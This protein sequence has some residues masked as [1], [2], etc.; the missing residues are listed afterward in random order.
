MRIEKKI[1]MLNREQKEQF[2]E[3]LDTLGETL[4]ITETEYKAAVKSYQAVGEWLSG[5][6]SMLAPYAPEILP[7]GSFMLGTMIRAV[8]EEDDLDIDLV[9]QLKGK[10]PHWTQAILKEKVGDQLKANKMFE[11]L[12]DEEGRRCWTLLYRRNTEYK[13]ERYHMDIL[14]CVVDKDYH[15]ILE[16][17]F[18][19]VELSQDDTDSLAI[20]ITDNETENYYTETDHLEWMKSNPFGYARWFFEQASINAGYIRLLM[21]SIEPVP[22]Y[23]PEKLPLQR[24]IQILKRHRDMM[25]KGS[26]KKPISIIITTLAAR[27]YRKEDNVMDALRNV[28]NSMESYIQERNPHT[29]EVMKWIGNPVNDEENF[30]DKWVE[31]SELK[32]NFYEWL[33]EVRSD[34]SHILNQTNQI[35]LNESLQAKF[36]ED[37]VR[38]AFNTIGERAK[39]RT[40]TG[41]NRLDPK[42]GLIPA[43]AKIIKPHT[44]YGKDKD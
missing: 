2:N 25:F 26:K 31:D 17:A 11:E 8:N 39:D 36:G 21:E 22:A 14:P 4:D 27:A 29:G 34:M 35:L 37:I 1:N 43:G 40:T 16:K 13:N 7:Q 32:D 20:R 15:Y 38:K 19:N 42:L 33:R 44:F 28:V 12:L 24:A 5:G 3:I 6:N 30:A 23:N 10:V 18:S 41:N 9:C